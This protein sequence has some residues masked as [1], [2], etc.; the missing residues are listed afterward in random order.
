MAGKFDSSSTARENRSQ[1]AIPSEVMH[2]ISGVR[3]RLWF[4]RFLAGLHDSLVVALVVLIVLVLVAKSFPSV[5]DDRSAMIWVLS[6]LG[7]CSLLGGLVIAR[8]G[9]LSDGAIAALI[10][11]RLELK[12][13]F[14][15]A[16]HCTHRN[17]PFARAALDEAVAAVTQDGARRTVFAGFSPRMPSGSWLAPV[18]AVFTMVVWFAV[19]SGDLLRGE[20]SLSES[21]AIEERFE[22]EQTVQAVLETIKENT[23]LSDEMAALGQSL[24][25]EDALAGRSESPEA[26]RREA[27]RRISDLERQLDDLVNG[28]QGKTMEALN[29]SMDSLSPSP[30]GETKPLI[31][32]LKS[33][34]FKD[35]MK[36]LEKLQAKANDSSLTDE[37][38]EKMASDLEDLA[39]QLAKAAEN[40]EALEEALQRAGMDPALAGDAQALE[41]AMKQASGLNQQQM[42]QLKQMMNAQKSSSQQCQNMSESLG[43]MAKECKDGGQSQGMKGAQ[44][45]LSEAEMSQQMLQAAK[46]AMSQCQGGDGGKPGAG[47]AGILPSQSKP[48]PKQSG[49]IGQGFGGQ[50]NGGTGNAPLEETRFST[51]YQKENVAVREGGDVISRQLVE[52]K[53]PLV[54]ESSVELEQIA[55]RIVRSWEEGVQDEPIP[56]HLRDVHKH[57]F[58]ELKKRIDAKRREVPVPAEPVSQTDP[59]KSPSEPASETPAPKSDT[60]ESSKSE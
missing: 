10:D 35:A 15:T 17:D 31:D 21:R 18:L 45:M 16:I 55:D 38:R 33:S 36:E 49:S 1:N 57:Y 3:R 59:V 44:Q 58:G 23:A 26:Q 60:S 9:R 24:E 14:T 43:K 11:E 29:R 22:N 25:L 47:M 5:P 40:R 6:I 39:E 42:Q 56:A 30:D 7:G 2:L 12:D 54:G 52:S 48:M 34:D 37:E 28:E 51:K 46:S 53:Q 8:F 41:E 19:P 4:T 20:D 27:L 13:R 32:A 50:G